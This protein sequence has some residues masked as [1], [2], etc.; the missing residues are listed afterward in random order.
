MNPIAALSRWDN[1]ELE[2]ITEMIARKVIA[3]D[4]HTLVQAF[5]KRGALVP[6]HTHDGELVIYLL[7]GSL[8]VTVAGQTMDVREGDVLRVPSGAPHQAEA[9]DDTFVMTVG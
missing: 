9:L 4:D 1:L 6:R 3:G 5:L 2:K 8:R 7:Q